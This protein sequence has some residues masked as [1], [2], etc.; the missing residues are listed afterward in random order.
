MRQLV[1][2]QK[3]I[4]SNRIEQFTNSILSGIEYPAIGDMP[5]EIKFEGRTF[6]FLD[7]PIHET[8][9]EGHELWRYVVEVDQ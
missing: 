1:L 4:P 7:Q 5:S 3:F 2:L 9:H 6:K 8:D